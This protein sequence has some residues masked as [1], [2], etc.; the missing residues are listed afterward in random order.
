M[1]RL[2]STAQCGYVA[3]SS[4]SAITRLRIAI[5]LYP[6]S[7][8]EAS[9]RLNVSV[10]E[11]AWTSTIPARSGRG[12]NGGKLGG[13]NVGGGLSSKFPQSLQS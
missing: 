13:G 4:C 12:E 10:E 1:V 2:T 7:T 11:M 5:T 3:Q 9:L 8:V 6:F